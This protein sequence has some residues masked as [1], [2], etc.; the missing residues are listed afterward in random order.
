MSTQ[1]SPKEIQ[2]LYWR[3]GFGIT[4]QE[5]AKIQKLTKEEVVNQ[6]FQKSITHTPLSF[7]FKPLKQKSKKKTKTEKKALRKLKLRTLFELNKLWYTQLIQTDEVLREKITLFFHDHFAVRLR[8][9]FEVMNLNNIV[10]NHALGSFELMLMEVSK[11]PAMLIFLNN[12]QN[13]KDHPNENFAREVLELFTLGRDN[14]YTETDIKE[15]ARA[16]T[17]W[18]FKSDGSFKFNKNQ[19]DSG[20]KTFLGQTG[21]FTG[22][23]I[24]R[25]VLE[26][27]QTARYLSQKLYAYLV[28]EQLNEQHVNQLSKVLYDSKY[29]LK[30]VLK[31]LFMSDWFYQPSNIG[32]LIKSPVE[33]IVGLGRQF[34]VSFRN[35]QKLILLQKKMNQTLFFPPNVAGWPGGKYWIDSSTLL[36]RLKLASLMLNKGEIDWDEKEDMLENMIT[37]RK[38]RR[39]NKLN[40]QLQT[41]SS[42][43]KVVN[44]L[45]SKSQQEV[46]DF[47][48]QSTLPKLVKTMFLNSKD[49]V[50]KEFIIQLVSLPEYQLC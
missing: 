3:A 27:K 21:N 13:K 36:F 40:R 24:L 7:D 45:S 20:S 44:Q 25:I 10:R 28:N 11:S 22:E 34:K 42:I 47:L 15:A 32:V 33:L 26:Q 49:K 35:H 41:T 14:G 4:S 38:G 2:H 23:D 46:I 5:L 8:R 48:I 17:G 30:L 43:E 37:T 31:E 16:F 18:G 19:H 6:L 39:R 9:P 50:D 1:L 29:N 12:K